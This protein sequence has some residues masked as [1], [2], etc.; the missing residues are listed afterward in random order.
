MILN[1]LTTY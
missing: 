1:F